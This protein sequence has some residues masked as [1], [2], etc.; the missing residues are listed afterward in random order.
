MT[1]NMT[2]QI[3]ILQEIFE[4]FGSVPKSFTQQADKLDLLAIF[5]ISR[6]FAQ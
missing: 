2:Q 6:R 5:F 3:F 4:N 1:P